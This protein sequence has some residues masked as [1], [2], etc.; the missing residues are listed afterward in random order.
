MTATYLVTGMTCGHCA[1]AVT[2][3]LKGLDGVSDVQVD[4]NPG[5]ESKVTVSSATPLTDDAVTAALGE[6]GG[7]HLAG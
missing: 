4:L 3:E 2:A 7:Y 5:G 6:A 1:H